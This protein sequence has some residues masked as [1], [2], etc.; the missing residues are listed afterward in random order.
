MKFKS[1]LFIAGSVLVGL[2]TY[3]AL[4]E[5]QNQPITEAQAL[6][7][8]PLEGGSWNQ[9]GMKCSVNFVDHKKNASFDLQMI[10]GYDSKMAKS[11]ATPRAVYSIGGVQ[12]KSEALKYK[13]SNSAQSGVS[14]ITVYGVTYLSEGSADTAHP[15]NRMVRLEAELKVTPGK[16]NIAS[17]F[18]LVRILMSKHI[19]DT[20]DTQLERESCRAE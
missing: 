17:S 6:T 7:I 3:A 14:S 18:T 9:E 4:P 12:F 10:A 15:N 20:Y 8:F 2:P 19:I 11:T 16:D 5:G 1:L 13:I